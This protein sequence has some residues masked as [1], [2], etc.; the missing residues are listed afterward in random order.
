[1]T[2][3]EDKPRDERRMVFNIIFAIILLWSG[4]SSSFGSLFV[5][6]TLLFNVDEPTAVVQ[7][8]MQL[9]ALMVSVFHVVT[10]ITL[11][12]K[13]RI[14]YIFSNIVNIMC[15]IYS[16][17]LSLLGVWI[18]YIG[19]TDVSEYASF[20]YLFGA[21]LLIVAIPQLIFYIASYFYYQKNRHR[22]VN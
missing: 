22:F 10:G 13:K 15:S 6:A 4:V 11:L 20:G 14:G 16:T 21:I 12:Q 8:I 19:A 7:T 18:I 3:N 9:I 2:I 5:F 1:M 17:I